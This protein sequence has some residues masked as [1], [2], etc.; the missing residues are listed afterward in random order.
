M[1]DDDPADL[2]VQHPRFAWR[3]GMR[4]RNGVRCVDTDLWSTDAAPDL[5]DPAT[6]GVLVAMLV[7]TG[8]LTDIFLANGEWAVAVDLD[9][10]YG[11]A[12]SSLGE[13]AAWA[14]LQ[15]WQDT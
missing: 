3:D 7:E 15:V 9:G 2:L 1:T 8:R 12:G 10:P 4:D 6:A 11:L 13:A 5:D 14:L